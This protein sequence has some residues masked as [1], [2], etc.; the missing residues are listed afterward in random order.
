MK[1][2][3]KKIVISFL[4]IISFLTLVATISA[5]SVSG[6]LASNVEVEINGLDASSNDISVIAGEKISVRVTFTSAVDASDV[7]IKAELEGDK[8]DSEITMGPFDIEKNFRYR[9]TLVLEVPYEL[10][11]KINSEASLNI[12]IWNGNYVT[13]IEPINMKVQ[14]PS[15]N[16]EFKLISVKNLIKAG[17]IFPVEIVVKNIG[18]NQL[19]DTR[20]TARIDELN[21]EKTSFIGDLDPTEENENNNGIDTAGGKLFLQI[22]YNAKSGIYTLKVE[23]TNDNNDLKASETKQIVVKNDFT[24][25][26]IKSGNDLIIANPTNTMQVYKIVTESPA[27]ASEDMV[28]VPAGASR[29]VTIN[30]NARTYDFNVYIFSGDDLISTIKFTS[31]GEQQVTSPIIVLTVALVIIFLVLL[32]VLIVLAGKKPIKESGEIGESYY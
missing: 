18:Y 27:I 32:I 29:I 17:E 16:V 5:Y 12:K 26:V 6:N 21:V 28:V 7:R 1:M 11:D 4:T 19:E 14:R 20:V 8:K 31:A 9:R 24:E 13:R 2:N 10:E 3:T 30:P 25:T 22:P 23:I 15:Y